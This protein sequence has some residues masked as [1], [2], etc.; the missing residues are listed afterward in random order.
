MHDVDTFIQTTKDSRELKRALAVKM[1]LAKRPWAE[2]MGDL[3]VSHAFISKWRS[4]YKQTGVEGLR[5]GYRGSTGYVSAV[6]KTQVLMWIQGQ[7]QWS[8]TALRLYLLQ[9]YGVRYKSRQSYYALLAEA[10]ITRKK[11]QKRNPKVDPEVVADT[12]ETIKK[13]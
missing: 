13:N 3:R 7:E 11:A 5:L 9:R 2:V 10:R 1:T 4:R 8:V 12:R 6:R